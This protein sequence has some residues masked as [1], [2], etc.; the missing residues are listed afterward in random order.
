MTYPFAE[1]AARLGG[2]AVRNISDGDAEALFSEVIANAQAIHTNA[3]FLPH[4]IADHD[5]YEKI[6][7]ELRH[8][9]SDALKCVQILQERL[10][11]EV[12]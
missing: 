11:S 3:R 10:D 4:K 1:H 9:L 2:K 7:M 12:D 6:L 5:E 8:D